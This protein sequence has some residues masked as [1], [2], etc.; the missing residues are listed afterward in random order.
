LQPPA[1]DAL[2]GARLIAEQTLAGRP[3]YPGM[4]F[5]TAAFDDQASGIG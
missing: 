1:G 5:D 4:V 2:D 3:P